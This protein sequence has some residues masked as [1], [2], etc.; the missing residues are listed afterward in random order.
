MSLWGSSRASKCV[1]GRH[2]PRREGG[3][4]NCRPVVSGKRLE[5]PRAQAP[6][7]DVRDARCRAR[8]ACGGSDRNPPRDV[9]SACRARRF[10]R[11]ARRSLR[12]CAVGRVRTRSGDRY[13]PSAIRSYEAALRDHDRSR[14][15]RQATRRRAAPRRPAPRRRPARR[16]TRPVDDPQRAH[17]VARRS[18]RRAIE[19]GD[20]G[21]QPVRESPPA[22]GQGRR[23]RIA[24]PE[25]A[26]RL[27][28]ALPDRDRP[29][30]ATALYA[31]LRRGELMALRW[32][33]VDLAAR[34]DPRRALLRREG[35]RSRS[36]RRAAP[37]DAPS[38]SS[39]RSATSSSTI[40]RGRT[41]TTGCVF[42]ST[43]DDAVRAVEPLA[44]CPAG[45][46]AL[47]SRADRPP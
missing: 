28:A 36:S 30:W 39:A 26:Q 21:G 24:S 14:A 32:E 31:G 23:E 13:K 4:C 44:T 34:R 20:V 15:R 33:D 16:G 38:R 27:L 1:T 18:I 42:G 22:G 37:A 47:R 19:N 41:A 10:A 5:R 6:T 46:E 11:P 35:P 9:A 40:G 12:G 2:A 29:V 8:L 43:P 45:V 17:A 7:E 3:N 25:E